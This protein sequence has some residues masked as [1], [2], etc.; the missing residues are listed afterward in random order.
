MPRPDG[1]HSCRPAGRK[2]GTGAGAITSGICSTLTLLPA[3]RAQGCRSMQSATQASTALPPILSPRGL[4]TPQPANPRFCPS[5]AHSVEQ[6]SPAITPFPQ[7][8]SLEGLEHTRVHQRAG[9]VL[10]P[11]AVGGPHPPSIHKLRDGYVDEGQGGGHGWQRR[12]GALQPG[13][14]IGAHAA[15]AAGRRAGE[16]MSRWDGGQGHKRHS[17]MLEQELHQSCAVAVISVQPPVLLGL[18]L[19]VKLPNPSTSGSFM[20]RPKV[21]WHHSSAH[22]SSG[23][24]LLVRFAFSALGTTLSPRLTSRARRSHSPGSGSPASRCG[25][26]PPGPAHPRHLSSSCWRRPDPRV[27]AE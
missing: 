19:C 2:V 5:A 13:N 23:E 25:P 20:R 4:A 11:A 12:C 26:P 27:P 7:A 9:G 21:G 8:D 15:P 18:A 14:S 17:T 1:L 10:S 22:S 24:A 6:S 16:W 3:T